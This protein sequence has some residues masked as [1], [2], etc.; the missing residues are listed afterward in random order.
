VEA[1]ADPAV[2]EAEAFVSIVTK[3]GK[4][5]DKHVKHAIG[6]LER[7]MSDSDLETKFRGLTN[8]VLSQQE[9]DRLLDLCW[10]IEAVPAAATVALAAVPGA[11]RS[12][13][14]AAH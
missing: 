10:N 7:P 8:G 9:T 14:A 12:A 1:T 13:A 6:S 5:L 4:T 2:H 3:D 11:T